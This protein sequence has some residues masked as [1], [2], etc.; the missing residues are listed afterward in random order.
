M[1]TFDM[2]SGSTWI[3]NIDTLRYVQLDEN[4]QGLVE[5]IDMNLMTTTEVVQVNVQ[6]PVSE[7]KSL[8]NTGYN[9]WGDITD[10][11][12]VRMLNDV[13]MKYLHIPALLSE[14]C[15]TYRGSPL[16]LDYTTVEDISLGFT[17][18][19]R[20]AINNGWTPIV[21][22]SI[23][24]QF[25][26]MPTWFYGSINDSGGNAWTRY[27]IDGTK[28]GSLAGGNQIQEMSNICQQI[29]TGL[30]ARGLSGLLWETVFESAP[31]MPLPAI[32]YNVANGIHQADPTAKFIGP[33]TWPGSTNVENRFL[34]PYLQTYGASLLDYVSVHWY[35]A[36]GRYYDVITMADKDKLSAL[37]SDAPTF[38]S[39]CTGM[40]NVIT[41]PAYNPTGKKIG[42]VFSEYDA[43]NV[44][45][46]GINPV[47]NSW[48]EYTE[49][50]DCYINTNY[51]GGVWNASVLFHMAESNSIDIAS[52]Y[53]TRMFFGLLGQE[54]V[55]SKY[56]RT[57]LW[58][59]WKLLQSKASLVE[60]KKMLQTS[61]TGQSSSRIDAFTV[62]DARSP[63][64]VLI[65]RSF[66]NH[67]VDVNILGMQADRD[68][69]VNR[70][71][72]DENRTARFIGPQP[73]TWPEGQFEDAPADSPR[74][75]S[76]QIVDKLPL[77]YNEGKHSLQVNCGPI[78]ITVL[79]VVSK[80]DYEFD[81]D[82][83]FVDFAVFA[84]NWSCTSPDCVSDL[85]DDDQI[86]LKDLAKFV[87]S[88]LN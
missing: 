70:Y 13:N 74:N 50:S 32:H 8:Y 6:T 72:F 26:A 39:W 2:I 78:S 43:T 58:Y 60:G 73:G 85:Y 28:S 20:A 27:N 45:P 12:S 53:Q 68:I 61:T 46:W 88:W 23:H 21:M 87:E 41:N 83:D 17:D 77:T 42:I 18:R 66:G 34:K 47:N 7:V 16:N 25:N 37:M 57:P 10:P 75:V 30:A 3:Y 31:E 76:L 71:I 22:I 84:E 29:A 86:D 63:R 40:K 35:S 48:P 59:A 33:G 24:D 65:N 38:G 80:A 44:S 64:I 52:L 81:G 15:G 11:N 54:Q 14:I 19:I 51:F 62:G 36:M 69:I 79:Q 49:Y 55:S 67:I 82:V 4:H 1:T 5:E 56:F 9:G